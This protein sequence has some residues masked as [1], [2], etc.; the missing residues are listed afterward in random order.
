[1]SS[2]SRP[3]SRAEVSDQFDRHVGSTVVAGENSAAYE[4][5]NLVT[6]SY[7]G[8]DGETGMALYEVSRRLGG[9][10]RGIGGVCFLQIKIF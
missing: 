3:S 2:R 7:G 1:M 8:M 5:D 10:S 6:K 9:V 4:F